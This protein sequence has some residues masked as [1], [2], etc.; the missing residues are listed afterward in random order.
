MDNLAT[1]FT[2]VLCCEL[3]L[4]VTCVDLRHLSDGS[5]VLCARLTRNAYHTKADIV[6]VY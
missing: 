3:L 4:V 1:Q 6:F 5:L 2:H